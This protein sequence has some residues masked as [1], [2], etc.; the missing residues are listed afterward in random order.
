MDKAII[1]GVFDFVSFHICKNLLNNG[2]EVKGIHMEGI[3]KALYLEEKRLEV[4]RNA[5]FIEQFLP[6]IENTREQES[7]KTVVIFSI[8]D[9][10][11]LHKETI[12]QKEAVTKPIIQYLD[13]NKNNTAIFILLPIQMIIKTVRSKAEKELEGFLA[14]VTGRVK[15]TQ[16]LYLPAIYGTWQP[17][18][19]LFQQAI[20]SQLQNTG[21]AKEEREWTKDALFIEDAMDTIVELIET[22]KPGSYLLESGKENHWSNCAAYLNID[23]K[24]VKINGQEKLQ[25]DDQIVKASVKKNTPI[26]ESIAK[27]M[28]HVQRLYAN[29]I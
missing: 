10:Y 12:L 6:D 19:F 21:L 2:V 1:F 20:I 23:E 17:S 26:S 22:G 5:N 11:M 3:D 13:R 18:S 14:L 16:R 28:E 15:N 4:G 25:I 27:Q 24:L 9:L 7:T 29:R 8:Y